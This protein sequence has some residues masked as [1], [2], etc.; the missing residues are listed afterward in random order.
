VSDLPIWPLYAGFAIEIA[1]WLI[2]LYRTDQIQRAVAPLI[3]AVAPWLGML[4]QAR[5]P[6]AS[7]SSSGPLPVKTTKNGRRYYI[8]PATG[9]AV[10]LRSGAEPPTG[11]APAPEPAETSA[12]A[13]TDSSG[14]LSPEVA[15]LAA[16]FGVPADT[17]KGLIA[18]FAPGGKVGAPGSPA[19]VGDALEAALPMLMEK[20]QRGELTLKDAMPFAPMILHELRNPSK[21]GTTSSSTPPGYRW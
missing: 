12:L 21:G 18:K 13:L 9:M 2:V 20:W 1:I 3:D 17:V 6:T 8:N 5:G 10:F 4:P 11:A 7:L 15:A 14:N 16:R 19:T